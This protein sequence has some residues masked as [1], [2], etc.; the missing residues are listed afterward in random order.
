MR[1]RLKAFGLHLLGSAT[2]L[3]LMLG[4]LYLGW[5]RWPGWYLTEVV[6]VAA[7][8][9]GVDLTLGP[10]LTLMIANPGKPRRELARDIAVIVVV[11]LVALIYGVGTL[12]YGR[13]LYYTFCNDKVELV[14]ASELQA[15]E[16]ELARKENPDFAPHWY[17][18]PRWIWVAGPTDPIEGARIAIAA[19][20]GNGPDLVQ[21]P[22]YFKPWAQ[23][24]P[25]LRKQL[26]SVDQ[27]RIFSKGQ[28]QALKD[29]M[30]RSGLPT[31]QSSTL[32]LTGKSLRALAVFDLET[33]QIKSILPVD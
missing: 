18:L 8:L 2:V 14:Q 12:W 9:A 28:Q 19:V 21:M 31:N 16:I 3:A 7:I 29:R 1:F 27:L 11:Q 30:A 15:A 22:R 23:G 4:G 33:L 24:L 17:S 5:Y 10:L 20:T 6:H 25:G 13:P 26:K 32:L